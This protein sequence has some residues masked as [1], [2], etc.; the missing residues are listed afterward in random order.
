MNTLLKW[1][2]LSMI[3]SDVLALGSRV[4]FS[5]RERP[6]LVTY[7]GTTLGGKHGLSKR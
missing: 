5:L 2:L 6:E 7:D 4:V 3:A 1:L